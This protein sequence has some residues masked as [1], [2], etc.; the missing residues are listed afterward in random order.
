MMPC[1][2]SLISP[3]NKAAGFTLLE[4]MVALTIT[5]MALGALFGVIA[6]NK[7]LAWRSEEALVKTM[8]VRSLINYSQ[9]NDEL[10]EVVV[11]FENDELSIRSGYEIEAPERKTQASIM[12]LREYEVIDEFGELVTTGS[13]WIE[14]ELPE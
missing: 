2:S 12:A 9:L 7:R 13:Y 5:G 3:R 10:G 6:G 1:K 11:D 4:V 8:Q 14:L